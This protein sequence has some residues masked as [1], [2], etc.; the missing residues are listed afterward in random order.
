M[1]FVS[2]PFSIWK[3]NSNVLKIFRWNKIKNH[4]TK[5]RYYM[6]L[7]ASVSPKHI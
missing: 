5:T 3:K 6:I 2:W 7:L 1:K 4:Q